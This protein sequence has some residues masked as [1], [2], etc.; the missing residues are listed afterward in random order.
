MDLHVLL[1]LGVRRLNCKMGVVE[2]NVSIEKNLD[3]HERH[4]RLNSTM[5]TSC[6]FWRVICSNHPK[7]P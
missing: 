1:H 6:F 2:P 4:L 5:I 3:R 7:T